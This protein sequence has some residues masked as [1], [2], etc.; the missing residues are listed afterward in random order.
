MTHL[1][2]PGPK[3]N[4]GCGPVQPAG[5]VNVDG[6]NRAKLATKFPAADRLLTK[7][8]VLPPTEF[9]PTVR[10]LNL[11]DPLP[12]PDNSVGCVYAGELWE[13][14]EYPD[15]AKLTAEC[16]RVLAP[17]GVLRVCVPDGVQFWRT[18]LAAFEAEAAK[19]K[20][21]RDAGRLRERTGM[22][23]RDICTR[24]PGRKFMGHYHKWQYDEIQLI[25][26]FEGCGFADVARMSF[27]TSRI[28]DV[29]AVERS[30]FLIVEGVKP[31]A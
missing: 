30:D 20:A 9:N 26:L 1:L 23:F 13:H 7:L 16:R 10:F 21:E 28:P 6:S 22:F 24:P 18:Y 11:F 8:K 4:L 17:G 5:W 3:L 19:P 25:D 14:F 29:A 2:P 27:H 31:G 12:Y 15:A